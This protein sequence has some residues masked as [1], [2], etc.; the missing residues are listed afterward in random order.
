MDHI[1]DGTQFHDEYVH[2]Y[3]NR[4]R[5]VMRAWIPF[6][7]GHCGINMLFITSTVFSTAPLL[8]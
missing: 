3:L 6:S 1:S 4:P 5:H 2:F 7:S 8:A